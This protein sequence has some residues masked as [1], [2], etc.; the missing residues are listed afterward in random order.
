[1]GGVGYQEYCKPINGYPNQLLAEPVMGPV[2]PQLYNIARE[3][4]EK[5][6]D[7]SQLKAAENSQL[8]EMVKEK[9][10]GEPYKMPGTIQVW[11][12]VV[13][14]LGCIPSNGNRISIS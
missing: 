8:D 14:Q 5:Q 6:N 7:W 12:Y 13:E 11:K 2:T 10:F 3:K 4:L 9:V 1:M